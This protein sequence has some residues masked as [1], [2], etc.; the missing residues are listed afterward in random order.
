MYAVHDSVLKVGGFV[1]H[2]DLKMCLLD[3][4]YMHKKKGFSLWYSSKL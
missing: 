1:E 3:I 2:A 4:T